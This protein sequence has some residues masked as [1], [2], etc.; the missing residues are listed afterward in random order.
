M[1][2]DVAQSRGTAFGKTNV[3]AES[4]TVAGDLRALTPEQIAHAQDVMRAIVTR[5]LP[6]TDAVISFDN[7]YPPLAPTDG[8]RRLLALFDEASRA[9]GGPAVTAVDPARVGAADISFTAGYVDMAMDGAG[10]LGSGAHTLR[11]T[12]DLRTLPLQAKRVA[13]LL[14]RLAS[15]TTP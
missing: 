10:L 7:R 13:V 6:G 8:N 11:E 12:A 4:A 3:V 14:S 15:L 2:Y 5:H 1:T 9:I